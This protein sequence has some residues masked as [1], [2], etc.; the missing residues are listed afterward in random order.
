MLPDTVNSRLV[1]LTSEEAASRLASNGP[2]EIRQAHR[3]SVWLD[4]IVLFTNP[5]SMILL[6]AAAV[7]RLVGE[8]FDAG[9][10]VA[11]VLLGT[12]AV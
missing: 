2:N 9:L 10:I 11:L 12:R 1:G 4:F 3:R 8:A 5:L 7:S 6:I